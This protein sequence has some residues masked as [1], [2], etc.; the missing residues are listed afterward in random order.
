MYSS[1]VDFNDGQFSERCDVDGSF[2]TAMRYRLFF[3]KASPRDH[4]DYFS[5]PSGTII[6]RLFAHFED[7]LFCDYSRSAPPF[8]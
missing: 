8:Q 1:D 6:F 7:R 2:S 4:C 5:G 3:G